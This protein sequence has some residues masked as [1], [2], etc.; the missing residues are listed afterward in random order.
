M[1]RLEIL[2]EIAEESADLNEYL[3]QVG[4]VD[5]ILEETAEEGA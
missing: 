1:E 4:E 3:A 5:V 2:L